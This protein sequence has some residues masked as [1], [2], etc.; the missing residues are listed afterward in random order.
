M[1]LPLCKNIRHAK[2]IYIHRPKN[3]SLLWRAAASMG[4]YWTYIYII[5]ILENCPLHHL[6]CNHYIIVNLCVV[7][8]W[9]H[10]LS[11]LLLCLP[12]PAHRIDKH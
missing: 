10:M 11:K 2:L 8:E 12:L 4:D 6:T 1:V 7:K 5:Q 9:L 3:S